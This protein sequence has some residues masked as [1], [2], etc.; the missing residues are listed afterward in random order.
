MTDMRG[1]GS[2]FRRVVVIGLD[3]ATFDL[4]SPWVE[5]GKLPAFGHL[6][7]EGV[8]GELRTVI[9][10]LTPAA[11]N[12]F[13]TGC[14][15]GK[16]GMFDHLYRKEGSYRFSPVSS[17]LRGARAIWTLLSEAGKRVGVMNLPTTYPPE[18]VR[19]IMISGMYTPVSE[20][21]FT[22]PP[23]LYGELKREG[24]GYIHPGSAYSKNVS[25]E[26]IKDLHRCLQNRVDIL[27]HL[28]Q[29]YEFDLFMIVLNDSDVVQ[30]RFWE[31]MEPASRGPAKFREAILGIYQEA[32]RQLARV[33]ETL[34]GDTTLIVISDHGMGPLHYYLHLNNWLLREGFLK[35]KGNSLTRL[36]YLLFQHH[37]TPKNLL[38]LLSTLRGKSTAKAIRVGKGGLARRLFLSFEDIDWLHT[39]AYSMGNVGQIYINL[40]GREPQG[41]VERGPEYE[42]VREEIIERLYRPVGEDGSRL[43]GEL[44]RREEI[45]WGEYLE[46]APDIVFMPRHLEATAFGS[47][48][49]WSNTIL[50]RAKW[51]TG[52]HRMNG[53]LLMKG[54]GIEKG[55]KIEGAKII[56]LAP[57]ILYLFGL[58]IPSGMD[59]KIVEGAFEK[60]YLASHVPRYREE[61][62]TQE[63][64]EGGYTAAEEEEIA[65]RLRSLGYLS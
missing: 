58:P 28:L 2:A 61:E 20:E 48:E 4:I 55:K 43:V 63:E 49:F 26:L 53:I 24:W 27:L 22:Y 8:S 52:N 9:P 5:E 34:D 18:R 29:R 1:K 45:Y 30:H 36:K 56:D 54:E 17:R 6:L 31:F 59:G 39:R 41:I 44:F 19:G 42:R 16:H 40:K 35:L 3:G 21:G 64:R 37:F 50:E 33:M 57:T 23:S 65:E 25:L 38:H 14:N 15:P 7:E 13:A 32:D 62:M 10:P 11:W 60:G 47:Y 51:F 46:R 12:S